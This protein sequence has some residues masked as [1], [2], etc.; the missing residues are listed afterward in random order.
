[1]TLLAKLFP[2][3]Q[4]SFVFSRNVSPIEKTLLIFWEFIQ[5]TIFTVISFTKSMFNPPMKNSVGNI[6]ALPQIIV[7][8]TI[9][10]A[11]AFLG[12]ESLWAFKANL[13]KNL[14]T[15]F[16]GDH[17]QRFFISYFAFSTTRRNGGSLEGIRTYMKFFGTIGT[18]NIR[19]SKLILT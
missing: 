6:I 3:S 18:S 9:R 1:M 13:V 15:G 16:A 5:S 17:S 4:F 7:S 11:R 10:Q 8:S 14:L 19:H 2:V 12:A